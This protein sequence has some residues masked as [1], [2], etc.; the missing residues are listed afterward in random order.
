MHCTNLPDTNM[1]P[2]ALARIKPTAVPR[3]PRSMLD[4]ILNALRNAKE[5]AIEVGRSASTGWPLWW[6]QD[7]VLVYGARPDEVSISD[8]FSDPTVSAYSYTQLSRTLCLQRLQTSF[9]DFSHFG[10][11]LPSVAVCTDH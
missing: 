3:K 9:D 10:S 4:S 8:A 2:C 6:L 11:H 7:V 5:L 1:L